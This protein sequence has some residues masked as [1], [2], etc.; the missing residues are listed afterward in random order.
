MLSLTHDRPIGI[1]PALLAAI[2]TA[3]SIPKGP[4]FG[5]AYARNA[6]ISSSCGEYAPW[7]AWLGIASLQRRQQATQAAAEAMLAVSQ[8]SITN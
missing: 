4:I 8:R 2:L 5:I 3:I 6:S 7:F 1:G